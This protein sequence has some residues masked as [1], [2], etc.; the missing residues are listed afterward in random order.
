MSD[1]SIVC[2]IALVVMLFWKTHCMQSG[3]VRRVRK[4]R[5]LLVSLVFLRREAEDHS[6][7]CASK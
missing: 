7:T 3:D 4:S 5:K 6:V 1:G 2:L